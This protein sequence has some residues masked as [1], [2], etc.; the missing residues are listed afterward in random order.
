MK[1]KFSKASIVV[2][3][4][5]TVA[6]FTVIIKNVIIEHKITQKLNSLS[7]VTK[8]VNCSGTIDTSCVVSSSKLTNIPILKSF[9]FT[10][11]KLF[12]NNPRVLAKIKKD[13]RMDDRDEFLIRINDAKFVSKISNNSIDIF[14]YVTVK[15][16]PNRLLIRLKKSS[17]VI[18]KE[19]KGYRVMLDIDHDEINNL[20]YNIYKLEYLE[21][22]ESSNSIIASGFNM[23]L[24]VN[25][26][27]LIKKEEFLKH[28]LPMFI[29][30]LTSEIES[31]NWFINKSYADL[32]NKI[33]NDLFKLNGKKEYT[34]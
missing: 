12:F 21:L 6:I 8:S 15:K 20:L 3:S 26:S 32:L 33:L 28:S 2:L 11:D 10:I 5:I 4:I 14:S 31:N 22:K 17:I 29:E 7:M 23:S 9:D 19:S 18:K 27:E 1:H 30:L 24:G 13:S 34:I 16:M 25:S